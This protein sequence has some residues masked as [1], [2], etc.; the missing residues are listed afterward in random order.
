MTR[1]A[2]PTVLGFYAGVFAD[3]DGHV[4]EIAHNLGSTLA[5]DGTLTLPDFRVDGP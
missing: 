3:P 5:E 2:G 4:W 1:A